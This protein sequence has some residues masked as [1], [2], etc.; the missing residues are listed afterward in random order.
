M[1]GFLNQQNNQG[2][3][4]NL[5]LATLLMFAIVF[6]YTSFVTPPPA[7]VAPAAADG[8]GE[9][10]V[11][12][13]T[14]GET[15][16][17]G[18]GDAAEP[19]TVIEVVNEVP[20]LPPMR[21]LGS[22][23]AISVSNVGGRIV[24]V[25]IIDPVQYKPHD[26]IFG[27]FPEEDEALLPF[28]LDIGGLP[29]LTETSH[30]SLVEAEGVQNSD[31]DWS[32]ITLAWTSPDAAVQV[33][34]TYAPDPERAFGV[35]SSVEIRNTGSTPRRF[36]DLEALIHGRFSSEGG[37][38][39]NRSASILEGICVGEFGTERRPARKI[40][41]Q[42][43]FGEG[44]ENV[45]FGGIDERYFMTAVIPTNDTV[46]DRC[47]YR[48]TDLEE[49]MVTVL[50]TPEFSIE[51]GSS[52]TFDFLLFTG[53]KHEEYLDAFPGE[54]GRSVDFG[55]FSFLAIPI[56]VM[57]L[58]FQGLVINWGF[59]I[60]LLTV[61][62]KV[63]LFP[64][65][66]KGYESMEKMKKVGP[67]MKELQAKY[68]NDRMKLAEEQQKL[69]KEEG[70]NPLSGCLPMVAQ[71]PIYFALYRAIWGS[72]ELYNAPFALWIHD[73]SQADPFFVLPVLMGITMLIQQRLMPQAVDN[74]Q[75][76][77]VNRVMPIMFTVMMLFLPS[78]LV[79][80]IFVNMV[81]SILQMLH[82]RKKFATDDDSA[83]SGK[84]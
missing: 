66:Q 52:R 18:S 67:R 43:V 71:M 63:L 25:E 78:G 22:N 9:E 50:T 19:A 4:K 14:S 48:P 68:E 76:K 56:R 62:I 1:S 17:D 30:Y 37:G 6:V 81:L 70:V 54:L 28:S 39:M 80:Y 10:E 47:A 74:P 60:I 7:R 40:E 58:F 75:M 59:A 51:P 16:Q 84:K 32:K 42:R 24:S 49:H 23:H 36:E 65:T 55:W 79:L 53:P 31:G 41:E 38:M 15:S 5:F 34:R 13:G 2:Q 27:V 45:D 64:V 8:S 73:L 77:T 83:E 33:V 69:F 61:S 29:D 44:L 11:A 46:F 35:V 72:A 21:L 26:E 57:L 3:T 82:I 20:E 12:D